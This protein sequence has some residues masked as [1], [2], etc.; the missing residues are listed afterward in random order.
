MAGSAFRAAS[1]HVSRDTVDD[2]IKELVRSDS[3]TSKDSAQK[4]A[5]R[6]AT[7]P[8]LLEILK[9][10]TGRS[11]NDVKAWTDWWSENK[12]TWTPPDPTKDKPKDLNASDTYLN[13]DYFFELKRPG[14][15]W[16]YRAG[17]GNEHILMMDALE[18]GE[19]AAWI[20]VVVQG[21]R[22][23]KAKTPEAYAKEQKDMIEPKFR[24]IKS[25]EWD[26]K[27]VYAGEKGVEQIIVGQHK[28]FDAVHMHNVFIEHKGVMFFFGCFY[29]SGKKAS[30]ETDM[31]DIL[32][33]LK[34][35]N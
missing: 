18:D 29:K 4:K 17:N 9:K 15:I 27:C 23:L 24:D 32:R 5:S 31:E 6:G 1:Q 19:K 30:L 26:K 34:W 20:E 10:V 11:I 28:D 16:T 22:D 14:K 33:S 21:V 35:T 25:A 8:V 12:S 2:L 13:E 3:A 7:K